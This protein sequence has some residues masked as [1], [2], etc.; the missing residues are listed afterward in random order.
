MTKTE[1]KH[2]VEHIKTK[3][4]WG[5]NEILDVLFNIES[6]IHPINK[7][8]EQEDHLNVSKILE[9]KSFSI[10]QSEISKNG[11]LWAEREI[12]QWFQENPGV[13]VEDQLKIPFPWESKK[14]EQK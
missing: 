10:T 11:V 7:A 6:G 1:F 12:R 9:E 14:G 2:L 13:S 4:S 5:K 3:N 8:A